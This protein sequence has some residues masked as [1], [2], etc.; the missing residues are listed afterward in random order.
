[1]FDLQKFISLLKK[2]P[3]SLKEN[4]PWASTLADE[5]KETQQLEAYELEFKYQVLYQNRQHYLNLVRKFADDPQMSVSEFH[6]EYYALYNQDEKR[7]QSL[8]KDLEALA[9]FPIVDESE[10]EKIN[11]LIGEIDFVFECK[12]EMIFDLKSEDEINNMFRHAMNQI[13][14]SFKF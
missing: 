12:D 11:N 13:S 5:N 4:Y 6:D 1:M 10:T 8:K 3:N 9:L 14:K 2:Y 7:I